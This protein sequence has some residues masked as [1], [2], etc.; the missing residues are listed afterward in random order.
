MMPKD[1]QMLV[2]AEAHTQAGAAIYRYQQINE[3]AAH[4]RV[5]IVCACF[6]GYSAKAV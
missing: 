3:Q 6:C 1:Q 5:R 4:L 2:C